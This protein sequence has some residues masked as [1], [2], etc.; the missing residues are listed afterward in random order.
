MIGQ[1]FAGSLNLK[2]A[3]CR[4]QQLQIISLE[5]GYYLKEGKVVIGTSLVEIFHKPVALPIKRMKNR[6]VVS[7]KIKRLEP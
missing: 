3:V 5:G 7:I 1:R 2:I 4:L 6:I